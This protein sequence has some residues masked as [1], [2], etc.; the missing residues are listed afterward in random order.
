MS[1]EGQFVVEDITEEEISLAIAD[2]DAQDAASKGRTVWA[3]S[4][5][6][7]LL[8]VYVEEKARIRL[9]D[10]NHPRG[11]MFFDELT[12]KVHDEGACLDRTSDQI[13]K[14][15]S[16]LRAEFKALNLAHGKSGT[17]INKFIDILWVS[18]FHVILLFLNTKFCHLF[19][20]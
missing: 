9:S 6:L 16:N 13:K 11:K 2:Q 18:L 10:A 7:T 20:I 1:M 4:D 15:I 17:T 5:T 3:T 14:K 19:E 8:R 12:R